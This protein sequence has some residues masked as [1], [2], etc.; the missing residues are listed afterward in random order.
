M[1]KRKI[2]LKGIDQLQLLGSQDEHLH[3]IEEA[4]A[5]KIVVRGDEIAISG[6]TGDIDTLERLFTELIFLINRN[7]R[8]I[9]DDVKMVIDM[10]QAGGGEVSV[11]LKSEP[12]IIF[13]GKKGLIRPKSKGQE[14]YL[15]AVSQNDIVFAIG[16]AGTG[17]TYLVVAMA[18]ARLRE[19]EVSRI[20]LTRPAIEAGESLGFLPGDLM[21]KVDPY[22]RPLTDALF[23]MLPSD[24][25][26]RYVERKIIEIVPLAYMRG[27]T[28]N[29]AFVI[30]D[31]AQNT[32][33]IQ[34]KMFLTRLGVNSRS[35]ITGD[36]T[37]IDL[38]DNIKSGL[39]Q[40]QDVLKEI[41]GIGFVYLDRTD[42][43][44]HRLVREIIQAYEVFKENHTEEG[45]PE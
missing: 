10:V 43:V 1:E 22:L 25:L 14:R 36:V 45:S 35:I 12:R 20:I 26:Q 9:R 5:S 21:E 2:S 29:D 23:D 37:Q 13:Y 31:E 17:K 40:I 30:L 11:G 4:F 24:Q 16:P 41:D 7:G 28:L 18:L 27:R 44:R 3:L 39:I 15:S 32:S 33:P 38:P 34:M 8:L 42:V 6:K 19:K